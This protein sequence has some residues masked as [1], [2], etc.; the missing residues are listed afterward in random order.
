MQKPPGAC[1]CI[2]LNSVT[3]YFV[4][5]IALMPEADKLQFCE[6]YFLR[7]I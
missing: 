5:F 7:M 4:A 2:I 3:I 6:V 1:D